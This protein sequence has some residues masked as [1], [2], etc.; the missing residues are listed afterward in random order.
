MEN[1]IHVLVEPMVPSRDHLY[2]GIGRG[3]SLLKA[4]AD[5]DRYHLV[6]RTMENPKGGVQGEGVEVNGTPVGIV[7][8]IGVEGVALSTAG[9][10]KGVE[11]LLLP[12][13]GQRRW[14]V[15]KVVLDEIDRRGDQH[16]AGHL[17]WV[18]HGSEQ[19]EPP[20]KA[21]AD[22]DHL[23]WAEPF[24]DLFQIPQ[25]SGDPKITEITPT[26]R[27]VTHVKAQPTAPPSGRHFNQCEGLLTLH[28]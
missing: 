13:G 6:L 24:D 5:L 20:P 25:A 19:G 12:L 22:Q 10:G 26:M 18:L 4:S 23:V 27:V 8:D 28:T 16:N 1:P 21:G 9:V 17:F 11:P 3:W 2:P 14:Q 7:E 15:A